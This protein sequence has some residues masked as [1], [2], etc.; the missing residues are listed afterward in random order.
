MFTAEHMTNEATLS[1]PMRQYNEVMQCVEYT[2]QPV[3]AEQT[4]ALSADRS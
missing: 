3:R 4:L 2:G 1:L